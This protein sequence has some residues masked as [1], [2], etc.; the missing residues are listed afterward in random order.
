MS[1]GLFCSAFEVGLPS[2]KYP[3]E[4]APAN[5]QMI[6]EVDTT[7]KWLLQPSAIYASSEQETTTF[8]GKQRSA[9]VA[10]VFS[11]ATTE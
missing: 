9:V 11:L 6:P 2:P 5:I 7:P 8:D 10:A 3:A 1:V 4:H